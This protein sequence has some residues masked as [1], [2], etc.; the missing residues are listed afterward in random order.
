M[1]NEPGPHMMRAGW[2]EGDAVIVFSESAKTWFRGRVTV[3]DRTDYTMVEYH[4]A[5]GQLCRK[6]LH[7]DSAQIRHDNLPP[8]DACTSG[9]EEA[10]PDFG[11]DFRPMDSLRPRQMHGVGFAARNEALAA[12]MRPPRPQEP[13]TYA[14][15]R[16][17]AVRPQPGG[18]QN[19]KPAVCMSPSVGQWNAGRQQSSGPRTFE[20]QGCQF[21]NIGGDDS[22]CRSRQA[23]S[24]LGG[25]SPR[26]PGGWLR[27]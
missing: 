13:V 14:S 16:Q 5:D 19:Y 3:N 27:G 20:R 23:S 6:Q 15:N 4:D 12:S 26:T 10:D 18:G 22:P 24:Q 8:Q 21:F 1:T 11:F 2:H 9:E 17:S 7:S 25:N